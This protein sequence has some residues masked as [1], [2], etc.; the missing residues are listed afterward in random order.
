MMTEDDKQKLLNRR[1]ADQRE[2]SPPDED[3][4]MRGDVVQREGEDEL[5]S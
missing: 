3:L 4:F 1:S 5:S 2:Y